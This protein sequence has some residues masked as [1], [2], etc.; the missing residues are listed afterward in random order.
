MKIKY[1]LNHITFNTFNVLINFKIL[2]DVQ[3]CFHCG[4]KFE[5]SSI[6]KINL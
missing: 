3:I 5:H 1:E 2:I 4:L 6:N